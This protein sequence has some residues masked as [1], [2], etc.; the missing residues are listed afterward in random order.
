M[1]QNHVIYLFRILKKTVKISGITLL[2]LYIAICLLL[3]IFQEK[4]IFYPEPLPTSYSFTFPSPF[5]EINI[6]VNGGQT[7]NGILFKAKEAKGLLFFLHGNAG[8]LRTWG[9]TAQIYN[10][11]NY[12]VFML[13]YRSYGKSTGT[14]Q[15]MEQL[16]CDNQTAYNIFKK[17]YPEKQIVIIGH[18]IGTG[19]AA[20]LAAANHP[21]LLILQA[22][23][24]SLSDVMKQNFPLIPTFL[25]KY[26]FATH[27]YLNSCRAPVV[28]FHGKQ[29]EV[30][31][32]NSSL[33][34]QKEFKPGDTLITLDKTGHNSITRHPEYRTLLNQVLKQFKPYEQ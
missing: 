6:P 10:A 1:F 23:Y 29:D 30:I 26:N 8:S 14:I 32:Y 25:L 7:I 9:N 22:P 31:A 11:L 19:M 3:F 12:D 2:A 27:Q 18:S 5:T 20:K 24:Y 16:F 4:F 28:I 34:L 13:D 17:L 33:K 15:H 21:G